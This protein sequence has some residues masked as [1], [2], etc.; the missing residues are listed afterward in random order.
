MT[1]DYISISQHQKAQSKGGKKINKLDS[2][3]IK[4]SALQKTQLRTF[5]DKHQNAKKKD[6]IYDK[7]LVSRIHKEISTQ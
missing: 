6:H 1:L 7:K 3:K 2:I 4:S 5:K